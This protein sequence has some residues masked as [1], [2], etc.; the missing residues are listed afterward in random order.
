MH[1]L[2]ALTF[3]AVNMSM[4][5]M[6]LLQIFPVLQYIARVITK[7]GHKHIRLLACLY[8]LVWWRV[9]YSC[10]DG[11][12]NCVCV[13]IQDT[14]IQGG[15]E[16]VPTIDIHMNQVELEKQWQKFLLEYIAPITEKM[17][18]GYYTKVSWTVLHLLS[19][20]G[21]QGCSMRKFWENWHMSPLYVI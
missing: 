3:A 18:P 13:C 6:K 21:F 20:R 12:F 7:R 2:H 11:Q 10:V 15:Y 17:Y 1:S 4:Q 14:R 9:L 19:Q 5:K 8:D 16:N